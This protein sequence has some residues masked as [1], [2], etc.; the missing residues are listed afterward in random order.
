M[1]K[2]MG[3]GKYD[4]SKIEHVRHQKHKFNRLEHVIEKALWILTVTENDI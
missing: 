2:N 1:A 3:K 4:T